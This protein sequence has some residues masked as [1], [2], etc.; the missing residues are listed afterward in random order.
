MPGHRCCRLERQRRIHLAVSMQINGRRF[1]DYAEESRKFW[2]RRDRQAH[3]DWAK[4]KAV[5]AEVLAPFQATEMPWHIARRRYLFARALA[6][7]DLEA[8]AA[9]L[10][11]EAELLGLYTAGP[12]RLSDEQLEAAIARLMPPQDGALIRLQE[13]GPDQPTPA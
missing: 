5:L 3:D 2:D 13:D 1:R 7:G 6:A 9:I 4:A 8:A 12:A 11:D 10:A